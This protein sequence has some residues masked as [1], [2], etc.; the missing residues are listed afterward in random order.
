MVEEAKLW[1]WRRVLASIVD[2]VLGA[3]VFTLLFAMVFDRLS[4]NVRL[5]A[6]GVSWTHCGTATASD[7]VRAVADRL[8]P[9]A[10]WHQ[11]SLCRFIS[12]GLAEDRAIVFRSRE[13]RDRT[14]LVR[15][16]SVP[17]D[18]AGRRAYPFYA[19]WVGFLFIVASIVAFLAS[20]LQA[21]PGLRL[22]GLRLEGMD[23]Y[24][25][26]LGRVILRELC[27][28]VVP[29]LLV[30]PLFAIVSGTV[31]S[32]FSGAIGAGVAPAIVLAVF[33]LHGVGIFLWWRPFTLRRAWPRAP[34]HDVLTGTR[35]V[36][37]TA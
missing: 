2:F 7:E 5:S 19:N 16:V 18:E 33:A 6:F 13:Q 30:A 1:F 17:V 20:G 21:T 10:T 24:G 29:F 34:L 22:A 26:T 27:I 31:K 3:F 14:L 23:G 35:M 12:F 37:A 8:L 11:T 9:N 4:A 36:R 25:P 15:S 32:S 28:V